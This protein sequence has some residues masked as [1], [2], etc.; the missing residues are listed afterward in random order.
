ML[1]DVRRQNNVG[2]PV[3]YGKATNVADHRP[4]ASVPHGADRVLDGVDYH[5][6]LGAGH[7]RSYKTLAAAQVEDEVRAPPA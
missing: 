7:Q 3:F 6:V 4:G 5:E 1:E 2:G